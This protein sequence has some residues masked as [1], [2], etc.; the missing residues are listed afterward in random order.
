MKRSTFTFAQLMQL[1]LFE[2]LGKALAVGLSMIR[3]N[4]VSP[5]TIRTDFNWEGAEQEKRE[6]AYEAYKELCV[7]G[8]AGHA[9]EIGQNVLYL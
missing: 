4:V 5:G 7:P 3:V 9:E 2:S 6:K 8:R 1:P